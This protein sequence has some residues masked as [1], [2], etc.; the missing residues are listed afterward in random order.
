MEKKYTLK[1]KREW[2][3]AYLR[4][5]HVPTPLGA[6]R[7]T[8]VRELRDWARKYEIFGDSAIDPD[9]RKKYSLSLMTAAASAVVLGRLSIKEAARLYGVKDKRTV[10]LWAGKYRE[11]GPDALESRRQ[12]ES[13]HDE[14]KRVDGGA[15]RPDRGA[16][17]APQPVGARERL[18]KKLA[19]LGR[20]AGIEPRNDDKARAIQET[21]KEFPKAKLR[22][23]LEIA[24][25]GKSSYLYC[26]KKRDKDAKNAKIIKKIR[27]IFKKSKS[28][29]GVRRVAAELRNAGHRISN[30]K[31]NRLM[32]KLGL[33]GK[34]PE[35]KRYNSFKGG[36]GKQPQRL[37]IEYTLPD[38]SVHHKSDFSC[39]RPDQKWTTDVS[40]FNFKWGKCYLSPIKDMY[41]GEIIAYDLSL[42]PDMAQI[43]R[44]L[45]R[46]FVSHKDLQG[47]IF[48]SDQ[49]WQYMHKKYARKL[50]AKGILQS[51]SRKGNCLDNGIM[52]SFFG[53]M[54]NEMYY[55]CEDSF[56]S[57]AEFKKAVAEYIKWYNEERIQEGRGYKAPIVF[58]TEY[59]EAHKQSAAI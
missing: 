33:R 47:L 35:R 5:E 16:G 32:R 31:V 49:G 29:Y 26:L 17:E 54:K 20:A 44:M 6:R 21:R 40:Q 14:K 25:I 39:C 9:T 42:H 7:P 28:T 22:D 19:V 53:I 51:M 24:G 58:R 37:L 48:H 38:G 12:K 46:A 4:G 8:F 45:R 50:A 36:K 13:R 1:Q 56:K 2:C 52:E 57:F 27:K 18:S 3:E 10:R 55:G 30:A 23:L 11:G 41:T 34:T 43:N 15:Q 59:V